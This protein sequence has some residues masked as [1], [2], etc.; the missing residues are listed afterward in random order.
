ME[1]A[2]RVCAKDPSGALQPAGLLDTLRHRHQEPATP[3][4]R[5]PNCSCK[6]RDAGET[7]RALPCAGSEALRWSK[8]RPN[9][10]AGLELAAS[11]EEAVG[12]LAPGQRRSHLPQVEK[13]HRAIR[14][15]AGGDYH[16]VVA[17][18]AQ[19]LVLSRRHGR[20]R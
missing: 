20:G 10:G 15:A 16:A 13:A 14:R 6:L 5:W 17:K 19:E 8:V 1:L 12:P 4:V 9:G 18:F 7:C 11:S 2:V 3:R